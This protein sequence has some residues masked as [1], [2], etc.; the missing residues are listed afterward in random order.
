ML[1]AFTFSCLALAAVVRPVYAEWHIAPMIGLTH[2]GN[3]NIGNIEAAPTKAHRSIGGTVAVLGKGIFGVEGIGVFIPG[4]KGDDP[5]AL[6]PS[7]RV[8]TLMG[9]VVVTVPQKWTEYFL[10]PFI[11]G[12][13]GLMRFSEIDTGNVY[14]QHSNLAGFNV[15]GGAVGFL[16][17]STGVRFD[18]RYYSTTNRHQE[19]S[20][21]VAP[22]HLSYLMLSA[23]V[24]FRR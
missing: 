15:G 3:T 10:R 9:N 16:S 8:F 24:V 17:K 22:T 14:T 5:A 20:S 23:G 19:L 1:R 7:S 21:T 6:I 12:G 4:F 13:M 2:G 18:I 11:S